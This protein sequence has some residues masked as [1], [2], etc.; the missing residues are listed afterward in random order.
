MPPMSCETGNSDH[1]HP[2]E[3]AQQGVATYPGVM[4]A[5]GGRP[6]LVNSQESCYQEC[7]QQTNTTGFLT[8]FNFRD[9]SGCRCYSDIQHTS[10][11]LT[12]LTGAWTY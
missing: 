6:G 8:A 9:T 3:S 1:W 12:D 11:T 2:G 4:W 7:V 10:I 5:V